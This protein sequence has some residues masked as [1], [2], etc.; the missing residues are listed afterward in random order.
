MV[1]QRIEPKSKQYI[2]KMEELSGYFGERWIIGNHIPKEVAA[3]ARDKNDARRLRSGL[4]NFL[5]CQEPLRRP[6]I[7]A[8]MWRRRRPRATD[9]DSFCG[10]ILVPFKYDEY[11][12]IHCCQLN[13]TFS[14]SIWESSILPNK[15]YND[16]KEKK[17][18]KKNAKEE[19]NRNRRSSMSRSRLQGGVVYDHVSERVP[20]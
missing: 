5:R 6:A 7:T 17:S 18:I 13:P 16:Q 12:Y 1:F 4:L 3:S 11:P 2:L 10:P 14:S 8:V 15:R 20:D 19:K 9:D